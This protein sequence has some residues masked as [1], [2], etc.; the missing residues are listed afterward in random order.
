MHS[1]WKM[2]E[3]HTASSSFVF[4]TNAEEVGWEPMKLM[5]ISNLRYGWMNQKLPDDVIFLRKDS[6]PKRRTDCLFPT[7]AATLSWLYS[8]KKVLV[9]KSLTW[10]VLSNKNLEYLN[11][12]TVINDHLM[13]CILRKG[14]FLFQFPWVCELPWSSLLFARGTYWILEFISGI[15]L[16]SKQRRTMFATSKKTSCIFKPKWRL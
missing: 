4:W 7:W 8:L 13:W 1:H 3:T 6:T 10:N 11:I 16:K 5:S 15:G 9:S 12:D 2:L 14:E